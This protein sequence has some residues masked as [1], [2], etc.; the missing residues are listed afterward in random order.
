V[1]AWEVCS[2]RRAGGASLPAAGEDGD[3]RRSPLEKLRRRPGGG[4][5]CPRDLTIW[6]EKWVVL[7]GL[8]RIAATGS[9]P[10]LRVYFST[11]PIPCLFSIIIHFYSNIFPYHSIHFF[12]F[13]RPFFLFSISLLVFTHVDVVYLGTTH[14]HLYR[15]LHVSISL[16]VGS[17]SPDF[18]STEKLY[19]KSSHHCHFRLFPLLLEVPDQQ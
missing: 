9:G 6:G 17:S 4:C 16:L 8:G 14:M 15:I 13:W 3:R 10:K 18:S 11:R 1:S 19:L 7:L 2:A 5:G 12:F